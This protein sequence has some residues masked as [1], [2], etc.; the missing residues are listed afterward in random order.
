MSPEQQEA[1][2]AIRSGQDIRTPVDARSDVYSLGLLLYQALGGPVPLPSGSPPRLERI[3]RQASV[4]LADIVHKAIAQRAS[5]RYQSAGL[6]AADLRRHLADQPLQ[7]VANRSWSERWRKWRRRRPQALRLFNMLIAV[8]LASAAVLAFLGYSLAERDAE[9]RA[10]LNRAREVRGGGRAAGAIEILRHG[11]AV[12]Q[13]L[14]FS[15]DLQ[16]EL[17]DELR[18]AVEHVFSQARAS[19]HQGKRLRDAGHHVEASST[20]RQAQASIQ[21]LPGGEYLAQAFQEQLD[22]TE[23]AVGARELHGLVDRLRFLPGDT[24]SAARRAWQDVCSKCP[25]YWEKRAWLTEHSKPDLAADERQRIREDL[26]D[27]A[28]LWT[29]LQADWD[30]DRRSAARNAVRILQEAESCL[31]PSRV[32]CQERERHAETLGDVST[33]VSERRRAAELPLQSPWEHY[34]LGRS[35]LRAGRYQ[36]AAPILRRAVALHAG[37]LWAN[38]YDGV[39]AFHLG[40][41]EDAVAAFSACVALAP[42]SSRVFANRGLA[43]ARLERPDRALADYDGA[44]LLEPTLAI[45]SMS[46]GALH[47]AARRYVEA[48]S[49]FRQ[50]LTNGVDPGQAHYYLAL[51]QRA[52]GDSEAA[53]ASVQ[54]ALRHAPDFQE[55]RQLLR[56]LQCVRN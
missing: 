11:L 8:L 2:G 17:G 20:L 31:G 32:L 23:K 43:Y 4:G 35:L 49:D 25:I 40:R 16:K 6:L 50:A 52:A 19:L 7:G 33:A 51:T 36:E 45:A 46:R 29:C 47:L 53:L 26:L 10:H 1:L 3:N 34:A 15:S 41:Y 54:Q 13:T 38:Y 42:G 14:P 22:L 56:Q 9:A 30:A 55:A 48:A 12:A 5:D 37:G 28:V 21:G 18:L 24:D 44:L 27:L 39:C